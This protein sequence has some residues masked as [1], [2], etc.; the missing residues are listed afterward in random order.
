[1]RKTLTLAVAGLMVGAA[2]ATPASAAGGCGWYGGQSHR[3]YACK[4]RSGYSQRLR[5]IHDGWYGKSNT[6]L[7]PIINRNSGAFGDRKP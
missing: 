6:V 7:Q 2:F 5:S 4:D 3:I 1:M